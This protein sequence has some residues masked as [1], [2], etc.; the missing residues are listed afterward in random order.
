MFVDVWSSDLVRYR[1]RPGGGRIH[2][3]AGL[4]EQPLCVLV[5][6]PN[7]DQEPPGEGNEEQRGVGRHTAY[8][9]EPVPVEA[10]R[11]EE[12]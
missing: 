7:V 6:V 1:E 8:Q 2:G 3:D 12:N 11:C 4:L 5:R 9:H 10:V